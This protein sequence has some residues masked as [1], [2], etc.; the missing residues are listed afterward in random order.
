MKIFVS[1]DLNKIYIYID[2]DND[3]SSENRYIIVRIK[4]NNII[5]SNIFINSLQYN[6]YPKIFGSIK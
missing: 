6:D 5:E 2:G 1:D 3:I 4:K